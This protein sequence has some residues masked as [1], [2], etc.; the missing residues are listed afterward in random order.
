MKRR[1]HG[2][3]GT[4]ARKAPIATTGNRRRSTAA[5]VAEIE[6]ESDTAELGSPIEWL[7]M[8][9]LAIPFPR[10]CTGTEDTDL[11]WTEAG[12]N[13]A[14]GHHAPIPALAAIAA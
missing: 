5:V 14:T 10:T 9:G 6:P 12:M 13:A 3:A 1:I 2:A 4:R 8:A 11:D 7:R